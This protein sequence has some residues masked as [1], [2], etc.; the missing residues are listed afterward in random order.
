MT[1]AL[2]EVRVVSF[3]YAPVNWHICDGSLLSVNTYQA[4]FSL[5]GTTYGGDGV[6]TFGIPDLRGKFIISQGQGTGRTNRVLGSK[7]GSE[8]VALAASELPAHTHTVSVATNTA[9]AATASG[10]YLAAPVDLTNDTNTLL[11]YLPNTAANQTV[12]PLDPSS[13]GTV[14][15]GYAHENRMPFMA[16]TYIIALQGEYPQ[17]Q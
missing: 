3:N 15:S 1:P 5:I 17:Q 8:G 11:W 16:L 14:G 2:G 9:N 10:N 12:V 6:T 7:G 4:L 13:V